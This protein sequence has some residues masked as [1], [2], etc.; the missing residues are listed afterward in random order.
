VTW[1]PALSR[2]FRGSG[3]DLEIGM[4]PHGKP[5]AEI[6]SPKDENRKMFLD[7]FI[8]ETHVGTWGKIKHD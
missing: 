6:G 4:V 3:L 2:T 1:A 7:I 8:G 5:W